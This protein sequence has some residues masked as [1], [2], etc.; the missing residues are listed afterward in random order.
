MTSA[1]NVGVQRRARKRLKRILVP[2]A[3][4][5]TPRYEKPELWLGTADW[6]PRILPRPS[7]APAGDKPPHYIFSFRHRPSVYDSA[8]FAGAGPASK[9][10]G[11]WWH[12]GSPGSTERHFR[13][14]R[15]CRLV[16]AHQ[17]IKMGPR[18]GGRTRV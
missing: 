17:D 12:S 18:V 9:L 14:N 15:A 7:S 11:G 8:G 13:T 10:I 16:P 1:R 4:A 5:G 3:R 6:H 2:I